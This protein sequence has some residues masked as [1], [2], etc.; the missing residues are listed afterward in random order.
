MPKLPDPSM[1]SRRTPQPGWPSGFIDNAIVPTTGPDFSIGNALTGIGED[2]YKYALAEKQRMDDVAVD[3]AK[4][5]ALKSMLD[6]ESE[7]SQIRGKNAVDQDIVKDYS[8]KLDSVNEKIYSGLK[9]ES[10]K[11]AWES[12]YGQA[13]VKFAAGVLKHKLNE[14]D[15]YASETYQATNMTRTQNAHSNWSDP[16]VVNNSASDIVKNITKEK[17]RAGWGDERTEAELKANL[18]PL[19][20]G[21]AAQYINAK[22]YDTAKKILDQHKDAIGVDKYTSYHKSIQASE[23]IDLSQEKSAQIMKSFSNYSDRFKAVRKL[24]G[25]L[26]DDT[27]ARLKDYQSEELMQSKIS[28]ANAAKAKADEESKIGNMFLDEDWVNARK[29]IRSSNVL[30]G[31]EKKTW[32]N[33]IDSKLKEP[34]DAKLTPEQK[35]ERDNQRSVDIIAIN[36]MIANDVPPQEIQNFIIFSR[37]DGANKEQYITKVQTKLD[38]DLKDGR[39]LAYNLIKDTI[40]PKRGALSTI[41]ETPLENRAVSS[42]QDAFDLWMDRQIKDK[43]YPSRSEIR[44]K[45]LEISKDHQVPMA[46]QMMF[47]QTEAKRIQEE[48]K[49]VKGSNQ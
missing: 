47:I 28:E 31:E 9:N 29:A 27:L 18:G 15:T 1:Q 49:A 5:Q 22:Q 3:D 44:Q 48:M 8:T 23:M 39:S 14:S 25:Q 20:S 32:S 7:Y 12:Y 36:S 11:K 19:W 6:L 21:V 37:L 42:A 45:A 24:G 4:N 38:A 10:Q 26:A 41:L 16:D 17:L 35:I 46:E 30:T 2:A 13:K 40:I 43:K 33:A 34:I